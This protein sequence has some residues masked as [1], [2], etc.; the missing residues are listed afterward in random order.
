MAIPADSVARNRDR[1]R[2][3][4]SFPWWGPRLALRG[5]LSYYE[6]R[7]VFFKSGYDVVRKDNHEFTTN[8]DYRA[9]RASRWNDKT[10]EMSR[11]LG[12]LEEYKREVI[13]SMSSIADEIT[14]PD[15]PCALTK[16]PGL[17]RALRRDS[18][19]LA[20]DGVPPPYGAN[21]A[22]IQRLRQCQSASEFF[23]EY[24]R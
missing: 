7:I 4:Y 13:H 2:G 20:A 22:Q 19:R 18:D 3:Y 10:I 23:V 14:L 17:L 24:W 21:A 1:S 8:M 6:P 5:R 9:I 11:F 12:T 15:D 16:L